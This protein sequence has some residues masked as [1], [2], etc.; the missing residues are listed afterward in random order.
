MTRRSWDF[1]TLGPGA[2]SSF[3]IQG[4]DVVLSVG[5]GGAGMGAEIGSRLSTTI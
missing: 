2:R 4:F 3:L 1:G 5:R